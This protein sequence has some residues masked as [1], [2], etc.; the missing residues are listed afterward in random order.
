MKPQQVPFSAELVRAELAR[1]PQPQ[2]YWIGFSGGA[3]STALL[4][5]L[6]EVGAVLAA[7]LE[8]VH[9]HHGLERDADAWLEHCR[10]F[11]VQRGIAFS[12]RHL[13]IPEVTNA[14]PEER[15]RDCRY[16]AVAELL[17][18]REMYLTAH[19]A[20]DQAE[21]LLLN[22]MRGSGL[23]GLAGIPAVRGLAAGWV[24]RPL[25]EI[26]RDD[27]IDYLENRGI[28]WITDPSNRDTRFDR[29]F[30]RQEVL[31]LLDSRWPRITD[32]LSRTARLARLSAN[33]IAT[34]VD[35]Q[36][37]HLLA[38]PV[39]LPLQPLR[40]LQPELRAL[41]VRQWLRQHELPALPER[42]LAE[43]LDQLSST[44]RSS[45]AEVSWSGWLLK[46]YRDDLWLQRDAPLPDCPTLRWVS[47]EPL[48]LGPE[49]G[50]LSL[51]GAAIVPPRSWTVR[52]RAPGDRLQLHPGGPRRA[53]KDLFQLNFNLCFLPRIQ[54]QQALAERR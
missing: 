2:K 31:P 54:P 5:A 36:A 22:L 11:C 26:R 46:R 10:S 6:H 33:A 39:R 37:G 53:I 4:Q 27:L 18:P 1:L 32:R 34:F 49:L 50:E 40:A 24:A 14:S 44:S 52:A 29:N 20:D 45:R 8:A 15:A 21:T 9:F 25:L 13:K 12:S 17:G 23:E 35:Q 51:E 47:A 3:D 19:H 7:P 16:Q 48:R 42:R 38:D 43:L 30:L 41:V 28:G